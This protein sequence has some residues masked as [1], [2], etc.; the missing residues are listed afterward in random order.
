MPW[1]LIRPAP[2]APAWPPAPRR[3]RPCRPGPLEHDRDG[4]VVVKPMNQGSLIF[5]SMLISAVPV[6]P[7]SSTPSSAAAVPVPSLTTFFI[8]AVSSRAVDVF[9][10]R[11]AS[12]PSISSCVRPSGSTI[13]CVMCGFIRTPPLAI[14]AATVAICSGVTSSLSWPIAMRPT[15][16][17]GERGAQQ[18]AVR[19]ALARGQQLVGGQVDRRLLV[20]AVP[21]HVLGHRLLAQLLTDLG[22]HRVDRVVSAKVRSMSPKSSPPKLLSGT[23]EIFLPFLPLTRE[24]GREIARVERGGGGHRLHRRARRIA[25]LRGAVDERRVGVVGRE[26]LELVALVEPVGVVGGLRD[27]RQHGAGRRLERDDGALAAL[28]ARRS[29][30]AA[31]WSSASCGSSRRRCAC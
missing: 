19:A 9:I 5:C 15:S 7:A 27:H 13:F 6:L 12:S 2:R 31:P 3:R 4:E 17:R 30:P 11:S 29:R 20:E 18:L 8:I 23:P 10:T 22:P 21:R 26:L 28:A 24:S 16:I 14:V 25:R 1:T